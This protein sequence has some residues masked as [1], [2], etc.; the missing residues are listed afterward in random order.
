MRKIIKICCLLL[1]GCNYCFAQQIKFQELFGKWKIKDWI[2][3]EHTGETI[4]EYNERMND[5]QKCLKGTVLIDTF[6][7]RM[8]KTKSCYFISCN[9]NFSNKQK[10]LKKIII[11]DNEYT[12]KLEGSE[13]IDSN[14]VGERFI[15][16]LDK[17]Y[18]KNILT[19]IDTG[20][21]QDNGNFT[22]KICLINKNK[23]GLY[24]GVDLL[25]LERYF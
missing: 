11:K 4:D 15:Q 18:T 25:I 10:Y 19:L 17:K 12:R 23:I 16:L 8:N 20:C 5:Y 9:Y 13:M 6:G 24:S 21:F 2:F 22:L 3:L 1:L 14:I 7:I